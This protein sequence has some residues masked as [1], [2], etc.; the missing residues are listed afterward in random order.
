MLAPQSMDSKEVLLAIPKPGVK[1]VMLDIPKLH[2]FMCLF[3]LWLI[4][5]LLFAALTEF[6]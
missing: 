3:W 4:C 5:S 6:L 2:V 1:E